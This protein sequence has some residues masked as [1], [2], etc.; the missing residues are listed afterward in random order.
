MLPTLNVR[1]FNAV[2]EALTTTGS[3]GPS[4]RDQVVV[5]NAIGWVVGARIGIAGAGPNG[6][7]LVTCVTAINGHDLTLATAATVAIRNTL[8]TSDDTAAIQAALD[9]VPTSGGTVYLPAGVYVLGTPK[10]AGNKPLFV[11]SNTAI[12]G[13]GVGI[14]TVRLCDHAAQLPEVP[15]P[16]GDQYPGEGVVSSCAFAT[17]SSSWWLANPIASIS[18]ISFAHLTLDGNRDNQPEIFIRG[19]RTTTPVLPDPG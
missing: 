7:P 15:V 9:S 16:V 3:I 4:T 17:M 6:A 2:G 10:A 12:T 8:V 19:N 13:D 1:S 18:N 14:T 11:K 5:A